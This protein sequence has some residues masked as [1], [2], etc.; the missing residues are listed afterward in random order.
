MARES[1]LH[2]FSSSAEFSHYEKIDSGLH[3]LSMHFDPR[4]RSGDKIGR[5][6]MV[7]SKRNRLKCQLTVHETI[8]P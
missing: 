3:K 5:E 6:T 4:T 7:Y 8:F 2:G 1:L